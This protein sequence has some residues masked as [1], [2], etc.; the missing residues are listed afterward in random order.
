MLGLS[1]ITENNMDTFHS[2]HSWTMSAVPSTDHYNWGLTM[3]SPESK[4]AKPNHTRNIM[5]KLSVV[6]GL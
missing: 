2:A 4:F 1:S 5:S 3:E 6:L